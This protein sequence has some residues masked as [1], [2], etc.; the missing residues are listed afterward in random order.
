MTKV[1]ACGDDNFYSRHTG[2][3][4]VSIRYLLNSLSHSKLLI[5]NPPKPLIKNNTWQILAITN[6]KN[7]A[8]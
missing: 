6:I 3:Y 5:N 7:K 4:E 1:V 2:R 8:V